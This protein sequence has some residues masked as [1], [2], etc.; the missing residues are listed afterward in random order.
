MV[1]AGL[2]GG[3]E[4]RDNS[5]TRG[6]VVWPGGGGG[7]TAACGGAGGSGAGETGGAAAVTAGARDAPVAAAAASENNAAAV[8]AQAAGTGRAASSGS[9]SGRRA[10]GMPRP[11]A[12]GGTA[13][14]SSSR[15]GWRGRRGGIGVRGCG[16]VD[17]AELTRG[18]LDAA[19]EAADVRRGWREARGNR[20]G[21]VEERGRGGVRVGEGGEVVWEGWGEEEKE[22]PWPAGEGEG[23]AGLDHDSGH[24]GDGDGDGDGDAS[25]L[26]RRGRA[27]MPRAGDTRAQKRVGNVTIDMEGAAEVGDVQ[28]GSGRA[29]PRGSG[30]AAGRRAVSEPVGA[31]GGLGLVLGGRVEDARRSGDGWATRH[32]GRATA[33]EPGGEADGPS[34][35]ECSGAASG[36][37]GEAAAA[38]ALG[39]HPAR[40][41]GEVERGSGDSD[42]AGWQVLR[43]ILA[44][45]G[46]VE[47]SGPGRGPSAPEYAAKAAASRPAEAGWRRF[48]GPE[49][50]GRM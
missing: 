31:G 23:R 16:G 34:A 21:G 41:L 15:S 25:R 7:A 39:G 2:E 22:G 20:V 14:D 6:P 32:A 28:A 17:A 44:A 47:V 40:A 12:A 24:G 10:A 30:A 50:N 11:V 38:R 49:A 13:A 36:G 33:S 35:F 46:E 1:D 29:A 42:T 37:G 27:L 9:A 43:P 18:L 8:A 48:L 5:G 19:A 4:G 45:A 26:D 3:A